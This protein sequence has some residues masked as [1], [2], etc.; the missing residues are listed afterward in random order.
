MS[1]VV[2]S[3]FRLS[4]V[5]VLTFASGMENAARNSRTLADGAESSADALAKLGDKPLA[6]VEALAEA[7]ADVGTEA[8]T[9]ATTITGSGGLTP[10][11]ETLA[12]KMKGE[13]IS[14][15]DSVSNAF[16]DWMRRGFKD[17]KSF[18]GSIIS[19]FK[20]MLINMI[21]MAAKNKI[22]ISLGLGGSAVGTAASAAG[23]GLLGTAIGGFGAAGV[24]GTGLLGGLGAV[25]A[26]TAA[27]F[28]SGGIGGALSGFAG[29][30]AAGISGGIAAGG[31]AG[32]GAAIGAALPIIGIGL[33]LFSLFKKKPPYREKDFNAIQAAIELTN[34][35]LL[36]TDTAG[37]KAATALKKAFGGLENMQR[38]TESYYNNF[39]TNEEKRLKAI[40]GISGVFDELG[41]GVP[42]TASAFREIVEAQDL[43]TSEGRNTYAA[44]LQVSEAFAQ[45]YG[46]VNDVTNSLMALNA[47]VGG[48]IFSTLVDERRA[49]A[50]QRN[51]IAFD[52]DQ[53]ERAGGGI[54]YRGTGPRITAT[55]QADAD[56]LAENIA[57]QSETQTALLIDIQKTTTRTLRI[58]DSWDVV[59]LPPE[60]T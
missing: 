11:V 2:Q 59:G 10:A 18:A 51:G 24:A 7:V 44:L 43:M 56:K 27:G 26:G 37:H 1:A 41:I 23:T 60:R 38:A 40:D 21:T 50:Y 12:D 19:T 28:A 20:N 53:P 49:A 46:G 29:S 16:G 17:F 45:V 39:F 35:E 5:A 54:A 36:N 3:E 55:A 14:A 42:A 48:S 4:N 15:V 9:A 32:I 34:T 47:S 25:G 33:A 30:T 22:M 52:A 58:N 31:V 8:V 57:A 13:L 6:S